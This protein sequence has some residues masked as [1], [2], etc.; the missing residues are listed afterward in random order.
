M[1]AAS[2]LALVV[3]VA[4]TACTSQPQESQ[5]KSTP[6]PASPP[7]QEIPTAAE[8]PLPEAPSPYAAL[9]ESV[10]LMMDQPLTGDLDEMVKRRAIRVAVTFNR[11][12]YFIDKG[13]ERGL[14]YEAL[15]AFETDLNK[16]L[17]TGNMKVHVVIVP[18]SRDLLYPALE[19]GRASCRERA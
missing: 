16:D 11:T 19:I 10:R 9:P 6:P 17:K 2:V 13:Q 7:Q 14:T 12:H 1:K 18:L 8:E 5:Q 15:K 4:A 3:V